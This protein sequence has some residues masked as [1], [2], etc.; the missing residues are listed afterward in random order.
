MRFG[1]V[2]VTGAGG[3]L[4]TYVVD[5]LKDHCKVSGLDLVESRT[6]MPF[7]KSS[8][9]DFAAVAAAAKGQDA[10]IHI[11]ARPNIWSGSGSQ[12]MTTN[13]VGTWNVLEAAEQ[14]GVKRVILTSSDSVVGFTVLQGGMIPPDYLPVDLAH[15]LRPTDPYALSKRLCEDIGSSFTDRARLEVVVIRPVYVLYPEFE[16]EV[17]ARAANP[18][19][20][21]GPAAGGRQ[22]AGGGVMWHYVDPRDLAHAYRLALEADK[23][24]FGPYFISGPNT[25]AP[26]PTIERL[27][28]YMGKSIPVKQPEV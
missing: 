13:A 28:G 27:A 7:A 23:P 18:K 12:I 2:L 26:E 16:C 10:I 11:A 22:P 17:K 19:D 5:E 20:Y 4:G 25:L 3:L 1:K 14:A 6:P 8:V 9:E 21:K 15:P 24:G